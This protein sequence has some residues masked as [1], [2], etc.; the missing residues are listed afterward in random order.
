VSPWTRERSAKAE[1]RSSAHSRRETWKE[2]MHVIAST[3]DDWTFGEV[4]QVDGT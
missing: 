4:E 2:A 1:K 3:K